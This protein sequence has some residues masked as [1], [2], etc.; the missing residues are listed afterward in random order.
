MLALLGLAILLGMQHAFEADHIAA[1]SSLASGRK[2]LS[3]IIGYGLSWGLGHSMTLF[4]FAGAALILG[5]VIPPQIT[6]RLDAAAG[7]MMV[8]LGASV[9]WRLW[10]DRIHFHV[11]RHTDGI[12]HVHAHSHLG[13]TLRH[14]WSPHRHGHGISWRALVVGI[15]HGLA[16]SAALLLLTV[17]QVH[18]AW[19]GLAY[20]AL[21]G[22][23]TMF[24]M[25]LI[26]AI[27]GV[28]MILTARALTSANRGLQAAVGI[29]TIAIGLNALRPM[30]F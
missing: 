25:A 1:V 30:L 9:L 16:G 13:E 5:Q 26:S 28:P 24:G 11:H 29:V 10:R 20:V 7:L 17:T 27:I 22:I 18:S 14:E 21:F 6:S 4:F 12:A 15:T 23:G 19:E 8:G 2:R 3:E